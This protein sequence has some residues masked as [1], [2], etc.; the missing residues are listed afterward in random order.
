[1]AHPANHKVD[2]SLLY[3]W[4]IVGIVLAVGLSLWYAETSGRTDTEKTE[5]LKN[6][7][8]IACPRCNNDPAKVTN[9][10]LCNGRGFIWVDK[11]KD[12]P[13]EVKIP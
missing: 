3:R 8:K 11:T 9:C 4:G 1:M 2:K 12:F 6:Y 5:W 7:V 13:E 10:S